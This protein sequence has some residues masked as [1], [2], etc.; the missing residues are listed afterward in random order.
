MKLK[1][2]SKRSN[3]LCVQV[4]QAFTSFCYIKWSMAL[5][6]YWE[7]SRIEMW[8]E[9]TLVLIETE[10]GR[11]GGKEIVCLQQNLFQL[12]NIRSIIIFLILFP[13]IPIYNNQE[14]KKEQQKT[15]TL[16]PFFRFVYLP[17]YL[18]STTVKLNRNVA[19]FSPL[20]FFS[21]SFKHF[22]STQ[23]SETAAFNNTHTHIHKRTDTQSY[24]SRCVHWKSA[25][26]FYG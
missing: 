15:F 26:C 18:H 6:L 21:H 22:H 24:A 13:F 25:I 1:L 19:I 11:D 7:M 9:C 2:K 4:S 8:K 23:H 3:D 14:R 17:I 5:M 12:T 16:L 20:I 10:M